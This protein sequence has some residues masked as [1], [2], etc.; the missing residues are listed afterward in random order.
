M[1][2]VNLV[3]GFRPELCRAVSGDSSPRGVE[4][5]NHDV[6][7][8]GDYRMPA[9]QND[10]VRWIPGREYDVEFEVARRGI[11][12]LEPLAHV[13]DDTSSWPYHQDRDLTGLVRG[14]DNPSLSH[15]P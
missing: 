12:A 4:G 2:G 13:A 7:G 3:A 14:T 15:A 11:A 9:K 10:A 1:G 6:V 5:F 8:P